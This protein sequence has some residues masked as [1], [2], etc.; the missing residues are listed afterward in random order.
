[1]FLFCLFQLTISLLYLEYM[2]SKLLLMTHDRL[3]QRD[4]CMSHTHPQLPKLP[5]MGDREGA[6]VKA[7]AKGCQETCAGGY[8]PGKHWQLLN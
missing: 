2:Y 5:Q 7:K 6:E 1:M 4:S 3:R 8:M